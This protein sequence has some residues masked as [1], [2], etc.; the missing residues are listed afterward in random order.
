MRTQLPEILAD[1]SKAAKIQVSAIPALM[2]QLAATQSALAAR[3]IEGASVVPEIGAVTETDRAISVEEAAE[4]LSFTKQYLYELIRRGEIPAIKH[5]K[6]IR[7]RENDLSAWMQKHI[8]NPLDKRLYHPYIS[9]YDRK[10]TPKN[11]K[12]ARI[13]PGSTG[14]SDRCQKQ[15]HSEVGTGGIDNIRTHI[16]VHPAAC[17]TRITKPGE[18]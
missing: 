6:Y 9:L 14:G 5:G 16:A 10:A 7:I 12:V 8:E 18:S 4:R 2:A 11:K 13:H 15:H 3:L 1:P 17:G